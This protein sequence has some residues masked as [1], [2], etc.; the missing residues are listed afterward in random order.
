MKYRSI[1]KQNYH[2][3]NLNPLEISLARDTLS[4]LARLFWQTADLKCQNVHYS[5]LFVTSNVYF[6]IHETKNVVFSSPSCI[7]EK[8]LI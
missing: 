8:K 1:C 3:P 7:S 6:F 5:H 4:A 2:F